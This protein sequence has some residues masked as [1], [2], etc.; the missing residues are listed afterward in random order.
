[1]ELIAGISFFLFDG[2]V[3]HPVY[4]ARVSG[5]VWL[6]RRRGSSWPAQDAPLRCSTLL[7]PAHYSSISIFRVRFHHPDASQA[8]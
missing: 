1:L 8:F 4:A 5:G 3:P 7:D 6:G 2:P